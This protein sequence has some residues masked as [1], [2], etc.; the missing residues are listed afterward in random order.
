MSNLEHD[1]LEDKPD[2]IIGET[3]EEPPEPG[4]LELRREEM[5]RKT[6]REMKP[7]LHMDNPEIWT[8]ADGE[9][10]EED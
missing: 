2:S 5:R 6:G 7:W 9:D 1:T 8:S 4:R 3:P 10:F